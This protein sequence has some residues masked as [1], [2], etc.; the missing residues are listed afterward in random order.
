MALL[1]LPG[2]TTPNT[3]QLLKM[4]G[5]IV[6]RISCRDDPKTYTLKFKLHLVF[7]NQTDRKLIVERSTGLGL[8]D[9]RIALDAKSLSE[10]KYEYNPYVDQTMLN[11]ME[12]KFDRPGP[13]FVI[14]APRESFQNER[15]FTLPNLVRQHDSD[16]I[17]GAIRSGNH[18]LQ[19]TVPTWDYVTKKPEE[20]SKQWEAF[21]ELVYSDIKSNPMPFYLP[22]DPKL[23]ACKWGG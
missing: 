16:E 12:P 10:G 13:E 14:L 22:P 2:G 8:F 9:T 23:E 4:T 7:V 1:S 19:V 20:I 11:V 5:E 21:G 17:R 6:S 15:E 3:D 18:V